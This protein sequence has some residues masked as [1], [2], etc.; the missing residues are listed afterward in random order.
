V[1]KTTLFA[2][3]AQPPETKLMSEKSAVGDFFPI[4]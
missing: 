2:R 4:D 1:A 3:G